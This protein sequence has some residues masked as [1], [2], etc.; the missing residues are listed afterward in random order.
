MR[1]RTVAHGYRS[2]ALA[3]RLTELSG[4]GTTQRGH[5]S[6]S[7]RPSHAQHACRQHIGPRFLHGE[8]GRGFRCAGHR[9]RPGW[10]QVGRRATNESDVD[11]DLTDFIRSRHAAFVR[12]AVLL[13]GDHGAAED[14]VQEALARLWLGS[15]HGRIDNPEAYVMRSLVN[16]SISRWRRRRPSD[17]VV[18]Q[19]EMPAADSRGQVEERDRVW[20]AVMA[21]PARQRAIVVLRFYED[22]P[23]EQ[24]AS[25][26][27]ISRGT[28][29]SQTAKARTRLR[30]AMADEDRMEA[31]K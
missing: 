17:M 10:R 9:F 1:H 4:P 6:R 8:P 29:R 20:R 7:I 24:I 25:L 26:L 14:L 21:L 13:V 11:D 18:A 12:R 3:R 31:P 19:P 23:E 30:A 27:G 5:K 2:G 15:R 16:A 22:L 28:V